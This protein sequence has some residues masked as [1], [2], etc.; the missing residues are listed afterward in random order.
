MEISVTLKFNS[1][2]TLVDY[3]VNENP[4][5]TLESL[6]LIDLKK[7][8]KDLQNIKD[9]FN[10][11][12]VSNKLEQYK[13][14]VNSTRQFQENYITVVED[15]IKELLNENEKKE[16]E[17]IEI[18]NIQ[19]A[20]VED[21]KRG[22]ERQLEVENKKNLPCSEFE[23]AKNLV[24]LDIPDLQVAKENVERQRLQ[25]Q[26]SEIDDVD[27][28]VG[29]PGL[30]VS[31]VQKYAQRPKPPEPPKPQPFRLSRGII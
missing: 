5:S 8:L 31:E 1:I 4:Y 21:L 2:N 27:F 23:L 18:I 29:S 3:L 9:T 11:K 28:Q 6:S 30:T 14:N 15:L 24:K 19:A 10:L 12:N 22:L 16:Q 13:K 26:N 25:K 7:S 17:R 20:Q